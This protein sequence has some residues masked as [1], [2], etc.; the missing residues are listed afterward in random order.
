MEL[1]ATEVF[2]W[3]WDAMHE[4]CPTGCE[5]HDDECE[6]CL[7]S[8]R[9]YKY[10]VEEGSSRSSKTVSLI[11]CYDLYARGNLN[12]RLTVW[13][14]TK[15]DC[16]K[17]VFNDVKKRLRYTDRWQI[18][19]KFNATETILHYDNGSSFEIHGTDD[20]E[21]VHGLTQD[22]AW[23]NEP[24]KI[25]RDTFDQ[26]DQRT[27]DFILIDWNPK[28]AHWIDDVKK[29][30]RAIVIKSTFKNNPFC[31]PEQKRKIL[32]Y[33]PVSMCDAVLLGVKSAESIF[34]GDLEGLEGDMLKEAVRCLENH[35]KNS[36]SEYKWSVY[37]LGEKAE[38]PHRIFKFNKIPDHKYHA[39]E[40]QIKIY[41][42]DWGK[43]DP[44]GILEMKLSDGALYLHQ[45]N[46]LSEN[47]LRAK[48]SPKELMDVQH[49]EEGLVKKHFVK[50]GIEEDS[51]IVCDSNRPN[52]IR[53][54]R[55]LGFDYAIAALKGRGSVQEGIDLLLGMPVYFTESSVDL[56]YEQENYSYKVDKYGV[57]LEEPEDLDNHLLDCARYG[58]EWLRKEGY[59]NKV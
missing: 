47:E 31:P 6:W 38:K 16:K 14:D 15:T 39:I 55:A 19:F 18:G 10:I 3:T 26:I 32:S 54:L 33:Q 12:K 53:A 28:K 2:E 20:E 1:E 25:S 56:D 43:V 42:N 57:V 36:A 41:A 9:K 50:L 59:I 30:K 27:S 23:L 34:A 29:D 58:A 40:C 49:D 46:Y 37:G 11:D 7:G 45:K 4:P 21:T 22:G 5:G 13:R 8:N 35:E 51:V 52:K 48:M 17:T 24:Y 44:W